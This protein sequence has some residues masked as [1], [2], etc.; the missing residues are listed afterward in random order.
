[1]SCTPYVKKCKV[2]VLEETEGLTVVSRSRDYGECVEYAR[3]IIPVE[4]EFRCDEGTVIMAAGD[5]WWPELVLE[6]IETNGAALTLESSMIVESHEP[7]EIRGREY[8]YFVRIE[9]HDTSLPLS[10]RVCRPSG[11]CGDEHQIGYKLVV[12]H[13]LAIEGT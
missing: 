10:F 5:R 9:E 11:T 8:R 1:M 4:Y 12:A 3:P 13:D 2:V 7:V 6:A